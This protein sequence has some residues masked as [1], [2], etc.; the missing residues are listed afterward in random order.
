[1]PFSPTVTVRR[2][3]AIRV[4]A[5]FVVLALLLPAPA[6]GTV[7]RPGSAA[8]TAPS[9]YDPNAVTVGW[10]KV[11]QGLSKPVFLTH[12]GDGSG[13]RFVVEQTGRIRVI[14]AGGTL[15]ATSFLNLSTNVATG[16]EQGL[17]GLAF[18]PDYETNGKFYVY[19]TLK[20][21]GYQVIN[22]Y[23]A[24]PP[25][26]NT[27]D[28]HTGRRVM[29]MTDPYSNHNGGH[30]A[31]GAD[32]YLYIGTGDG[33][34]AG[35]PGNRAQST[36]NVL[37]KMLRINVNPPFISGR[38]YGVP[39]D[40]PYVGIAG[41]DEIWSRGLRNP[42]GW[43]FDRSTNDLYIADVG[44]NRYEELNISLAP[45]AGRNVNYGWRVMEG[46]H[47]YSP[48]SG[49]ATSGKV[50]PQLEYGHSSGNCSITGGYVYRGTASPVLDGGYFF[51][52]YCS[53]RLWSIPA[54]STFPVNKVQHIDSAYNIS[55]FGEDEA[56]EVYVVFHQGLVYRLVGT[57]K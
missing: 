45:N 12:A 5:L 54:Q 41:Y 31:F 24:N 44:Q 2:G 13:R 39:G 6:A 52:D 29:T 46:R 14:T 47:C 40:N 1:M 27:V 18:H 55:G 35:D 3:T 43:S 51:A 32:G 33:G 10:T 9:A 49:C 42:W 53:G 17:L 21:S 56:G 36:V 22:E 8:A 11:A 15:L 34:S 23:T 26:A 7:A 20:S 38:G 25:S 37:G 50:Q 4:A 48:M 30:I 57:P 16:S 19:F 28:W